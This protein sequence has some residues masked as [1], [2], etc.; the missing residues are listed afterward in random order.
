MPISIGDTGFE[1][2]RDMALEYQNGCWQK[3]FKSGKRI[4]LIID[5][6]KISIW[7]VT[8]ENTESRTFQLPV[9]WILAENSSEE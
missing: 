8:K 4:H 1:L 3:T 6:Q 2:K 7:A 9:E 5:D